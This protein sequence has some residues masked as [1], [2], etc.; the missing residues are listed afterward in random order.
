MRNFPESKSSICT[1]MR[2]F[3]PLRIRLILLVLMLVIPAF[4]LVLY[5][6]FEQRRIEK[7]RVREE[8]IAIAQLA[9]ANQ[10]NFI[11]NARQLL[12]TLSE[13]PFLVLAT[14]RQFC[15]VHFSNLL[16]LS[17][18]YLNFGLI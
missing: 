5:G 6:N 10:Q 9:A 1:P 3:A 16:K 15:E 11:K 13:F 12:V 2:F 4:G 17:P 18:D 7:E 8:A 14:N